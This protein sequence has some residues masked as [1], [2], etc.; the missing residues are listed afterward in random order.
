MNEQNLMVKGIKDMIDE[1]QSKKLDK[2]LT[3]IDDLAIALKKHYDHDYAAREL[4]VGKIADLDIKLI[5]KISSLDLNQNNKQFNQ[6]IID[7]LSKLDQ[8]VKSKNDIAG[9]DSIINNCEF[10]IFKHH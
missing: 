4:I 1:H 8:F 9:L 2:Q 10:Q 3:R 6:I 5:Q 7:K